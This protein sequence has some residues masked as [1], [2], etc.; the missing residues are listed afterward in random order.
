MAGEDGKYK[1]RVAAKRLH[2]SDVEKLE[3]R[4]SKRARENVGEAV[5]EGNCEGVTPAP[6][7]I[8]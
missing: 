1:A 6:L 3:R 7:N 2:L 8:L 4:D 5:D